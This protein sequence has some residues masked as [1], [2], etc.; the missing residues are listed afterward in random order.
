LKRVRSLQ[1]LLM[2]SYSNIVLSVRR[3]TQLNAGRKTPGV[4]KLLVLI[5]M[6]RSYITESA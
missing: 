6:N 4:D 1:K 5:V 2:R 3:V